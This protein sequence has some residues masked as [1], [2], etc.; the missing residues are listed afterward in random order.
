MQ[1]PSKKPKKFYRAQSTEKQ[2]EEASKE[3]EKAAERWAKAATK[4]AMFRDRAAFAAKEESVKRNHWMKMQQK[5][6][7]AEEEKNKEKGEAINE[8]T[9][10]FRRLRKMK[11]C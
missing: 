6:R 9:K 4:A 1:A 10:T 2:S 11:Q 3:S 8:E 7:E 5:E